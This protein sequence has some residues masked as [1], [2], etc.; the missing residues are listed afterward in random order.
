[1][2]FKNKFCI[3]IFIEYTGTLCI[4][5]IARDI[6]RMSELFGDISYITLQKL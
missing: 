4:S 5:I 3:F 6:L 2:N 1:M